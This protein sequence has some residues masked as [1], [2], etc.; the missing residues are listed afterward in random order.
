[1]TVTDI[2][3]GKVSAIWS[4]GPKSTVFDALRLMSEKEIGA[5]LVMDGGGKPVGIFSERDYARKVELDGRTSKE[6]AIGEIMTP[7]ADMYGLKPE[8]T[9]EEAM[10]LITRKKVRHLPVCNGNGVIGFVSIGD[11]LK[12]IIDDQET[13]IENLNNYISGK[14]V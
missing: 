2:L 8:S 11:V 5:V 1:M 14:Y 12:S 10:I 4:L 9:V 6:T 7:V 3:K 13:Q